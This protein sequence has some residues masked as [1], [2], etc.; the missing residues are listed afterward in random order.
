MIYTRVI[1]RPHPAQCKI[2]QHIG[3]FKVVLCGRRFGKTDILMYVA[4]RYLA[5]G[6]RVGIFSPNLKFIEEV[7]EYFLDIFDGV[8]G[9]RVNAQK[10]RIRL[11]NGGL[12]DLWSLN[13]S[14]ERK[15]GRGRDYHVVLYDESQ[16]IDDRLLEWNFEKAVS[17]TLLKFGGKAWFFGTMPENL[18][19]FFARKFRAGLA[20]NLEARS[21]FGYAPD[22]EP[23]SPDPDWVSF[24][25]PTHSNPHIPPQEIESLRK[26][27]PYYVFAREVETR[28]IESTGNLFIRAMESLD[29]QS[30]VFAKPRLPNTL[31]LTLAFDFNTGIMACVLFRH[32][33][34][35]SEIEAIAEFGGTTSS[36][37]IYDTIAQVQQ[38]FIDNYNVTVGEL[39]G[40]Q[41]GWRL[42]M[43]VK[44]TGDASGRATFGN[45]PENMSFY[46]ILQ[47]KF[48][49]PTEAFAVRAV[50]PTHK[51]SR[52]QCEAYIE[53]HPNLRIDPVACPKLKSDMVTA[54][55]TPD[56]KLD[57]KKKDPHYLDCFRYFLIA[58]TPLICGF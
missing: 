34:N 30:R 56:G 15:N 29:I 46:G 9:V 1:N 26:K 36:H 6:K 32:T 38:W 10:R 23:E 18:N 3:R 57:K 40:R 19:S 5:A 11:P 42:P 51:V 49:A 58:R 8:D 39:H 47:K 31:P 45:T 25:Q 35:F 54:G 21:V 20:N 41:Y 12:V 13:S 43:I 44:I 50:N 52:T 48:G 55:A 2:I 24:R 53:K 22:I 4:L 37:T 33:R 14:K 17:P 28:F 7:W 27:L 16:D